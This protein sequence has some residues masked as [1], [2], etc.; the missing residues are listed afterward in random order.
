MI[1]SGPSPG[2]FSGSGAHGSE[3]TRYIISGASPINPNY[4]SLSSKGHGSA[5]LSGGFG[6][7]GA[8][9]KIIIIK[10]SSSSPHSSSSSYPG[11]HMFSSAPSIGGSFKTTRGAILGNQG[12]SYS[13]IPSFAGGSSPNYSSRFTSGGP[14]PTYMTAS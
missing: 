2:H 3:G 14:Y 6:G 5:Y 4:G 9:G 1:I 7:S 13:Y 12:A 8:S 11:S 10:D